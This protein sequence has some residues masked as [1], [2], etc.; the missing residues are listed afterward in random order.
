MASAA[1]PSGWPHLDRGEPGGAESEE[2][3]F[4]HGPCTTGWDPAARSANGGGGGQ[5]PAAPAPSVPPS[6][7]TATGAVVR[8][9]RASN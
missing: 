3:A 1:G 2:P 9:E 6:P 4:Y 5:L 7:S 8:T